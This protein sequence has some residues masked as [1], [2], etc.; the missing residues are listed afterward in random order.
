MNEASNRGPL[1]LIRDYFLHKWNKFFTKARP[2]EV[3]I[4]FQLK[5]C[6]LA[7]GCSNL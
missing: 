3:L 4:D 2:A 6:G 7:I 1:L 5:F